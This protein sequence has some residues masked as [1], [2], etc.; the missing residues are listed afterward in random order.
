M[1]LSLGEKNLIAL[2][3][4]LDLEV[5]DSSFKEFLALFQKYKDA[6][7][8]MPNDWAKAADSVD[9]LAAQFSAMT[10]AML[11]QAEL[12]R[13]VDREER[14]LDRTTRSV[15]DSW[16]TVSRGAKEVYDRVADT[17][18]MLI[19]WTGITGLFGGLLG[20]GGILGLD[21]MA[22]NAS[23]LRT[24]ALGI[25][26]SPTALL[27]ARV[28]YGQF[29][30]AQGALG[31]IAG[32]Q[33]QLGGQV[34]FNTLGIP[35][36]WGADPSNALSESVAAV[37]RLYRQTPAGQRQMMPWY[38][39][40]MRIFGSDEAIRTIGNM[41][42]QEIA[43]RGAAYNQ[44]I[45]GGFGL[46]TDTLQAAQHFQIQ[47]ERV[48]YVL[49]YSFL[50]ALDKV[51]PDLEKLSASIGE[52]VAAFI[53][54]PGFVNLVDLVE[55]GLHSLADWMASPDFKDDVDAFIKD[56]GALAKSIRNA[57]ETIGLIPSSTPGW[58]DQNLWQHWH[59]AANPY[60]VGGPDMGIVRDP[61]SPL[62]R[63]LH[64]PADQ[65]GGAA[66]WAGHPLGWLWGQ[67][68]GSADKTAWENQSTISDPET[69]AAADII[70][71]RESQDRDVNNFMYHVTGRNA[72]GVDVGYT[73]SG[74]Y[75]ML[76][77]N[78]HKYG[79]GIVDFDKYPHA[80]GAP[81]GLQDQVFAKM[82]HAEGYHPWDSAH[83][84]SVSNDRAFYAQLHQRMVAD[85]STVTPA[86]RPT[87]G[88]TGWGYDFASKLKPNWNMHA[89]V[90][91]TLNNNTGQAA[92]VS[93]GQVG[94]G[95]T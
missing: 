28:N 6:L 89:K 85:P 59:D 36:A 72:E 39:Q 64:P 30:N 14:Q 5:N 34:A 22:E 45:R 46:G 42:D 3:S 12:I 35:G 92:T 50:A 52:S 47:L 7:K 43:Q 51:F 62:Q 82:Y 88:G 11:A 13:R 77:T 86:D 83:G 63:L 9:P 40:A 18:R 71:A 31:Q 2:R 76:D 55:E 91:V 17:T 79:A 25:G 10:A 94:A 60:I 19:R 41:S 16:R 8:D 26:T 37:H 68:T 95:P 1:F 87:G 84:G 73:A 48:G 27:A 24:G 66:P 57:L 93:V 33:Q 29:F 54:G 21:R 56:V 32:L 90:G 15:A 75:Q 70:A 53:K 69:R 44:D 23:A 74:Y 67:I 38:Q 49:E 58:G 78:W 80:R 65:P 20:F 61:R 4:V 81:R